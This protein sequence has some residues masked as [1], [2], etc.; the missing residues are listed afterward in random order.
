MVREGSCPSAGISMKAPLCEMF[1]KEREEPS[2]QMEVYILENIK[3]TCLMEKVF[4]SMSIKT[5]TKGIS[6]RG[7][8]MVEESI[9]F[10]KEVSILGI[11]KTTIKHREY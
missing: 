11:G 2:T 1:N 7:K 5:C 10:L 3:T 9:C 6:T 8:S 4:L